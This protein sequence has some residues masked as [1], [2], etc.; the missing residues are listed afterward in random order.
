MHAR[1]HKVAEPSAEKDKTLSEYERKRL[2]KM[3]AN[4]SFLA[5][6]GIKNDQMELTVK[7]GGSKAKQHK[8]VTT[9]AKPKWMTE[10]SPTRRSSRI[11]KMPAE[12]VVYAPTATETVIDE[13]NSAIEDHSFDDSNVLRYSCEDHVDKKPGST[14]SEAGLV[15]HHKPSDKSLVGFTANSSLPTLADPA[16][17]RIYSISFT[18]FADNGLVATGGHQGLVSIYPLQASSSSDD[19]MAPLLS[20]RAHKGWISSVSLAK[21][22]AGQRNILI[23]ASNDALVKVWDLNRVSAATKTAKEVFQT[24]ELHRSGIFGMDVLANTVVTCGK[25]STVTVA[26]FRDDGSSLEAEQRY[27]EHNGV[28]KS[29]HISRPTPTLLVSAG[30]DRVLRV[31]DTKMKGGE[32]LQIP[33]AHTRAINSVQFHPTDDNLVLSASFDPDLHL[34]DLR[35]PSAPLF[36]FRGH[37]L[38]ANQNAIYHPVFVNGGSEI[39]AA[40][41]SRCLQ[42][43]LYSSRDGST[44]SRGFIG[45]KTDYIAADPFYERVFVASGASILSCGYRWG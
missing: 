17:K 8:P 37:Y 12:V 38:D 9:K 26:R 19:A 30:N 35:R 23:T 45:T 15:P 22:D 3:E 13:N 24:S 28:V 34:F 10:R 27:S 18:P 21:S 41:G 44:I 1:E 40:G 31:F 2:A 6:L 33:D 5:Q 4:A 32:V 14:D 7:L 29:V 42:L 16:L 43:S 25:D 11:R 20:F 36:T 39:V